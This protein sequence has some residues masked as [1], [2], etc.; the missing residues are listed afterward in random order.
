MKSKSNQPQSTEEVRP[1][2]FEYK[3]KSQWLVL[4]LW[5]FIGTLMI[6]VSFFMPK[7]DTI[8]TGIGQLLACILLTY[9]SYVDYRIDYP[10]ERQKY[11]P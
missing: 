10:N 2:F 1:T 4:G 5:A 11:K 3:S 6:V 9:L 7:H 8:G